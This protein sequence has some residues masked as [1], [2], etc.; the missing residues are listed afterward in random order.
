MRPSLVALALTSLALGGC[1]SSSGLAHPAPTEPEA[2][3]APPAL[4][5]GEDF[6]VFTGEGVRV[7]LETAIEAAG[8]VEVVFF[9]EEHDDLNTHRVQAEVLR[10]LYARYSRAGGPSPHPGAQGVATP[11]GRGDRTVVLSLEMFERDVQSILDEYLAD[12]ITESHFR[13]SARPWER[14]ETDYRPAVEFAKA[15]GMSV[16]AA[17]APRRYVNRVSR[18]GRES[19]DALSAEAKRFLP[20]LPYPGP[21]EDYQAE[22]DALMGPAAQHMTGSPFD[23]QL[24]WDA[25][26]AHAV[27]G[28][29]DEVEAGLVLHL[30]GSFHVANHTG[31]PEALDH[32]RPGTPAMVLVARPA[33]DLS[34]LPEEFLGQGDFVI[35]TYRERTEG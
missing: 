3:A 22:W 34:S 33:E 20:P 23:G 13:A 12:L 2:P 24:L 4:A 8:A 9:G 35:L 19:L 29:L 1:A 31:T 21:S 15:H 30:A 5:E 6:A 11:T 26:M 16:V 18:L 27:A 32:Y 17:N 14:Y 7:D 25:A 10:R 28:A